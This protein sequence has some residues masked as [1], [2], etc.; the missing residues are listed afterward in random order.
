MLKSLGISTWVLC[1]SHMQCLHSEVHSHCLLFNSSKS[2][3]PQPPFSASFS[4]VQLYSISIFCK[5]VCVPNVRELDA[6]GY[7]YNCT[8]V[9][10][11]GQKCSSRICRCHQRD[12]VWKGIDDVPC[13]CYRN[14]AKRWGDRS[15]RMRGSYRQLTWVF[16]LVWYSVL[17]LP[18][19]AS[20]S[21]ALLPLFPAPC[22]W[23]YVL[24]FPKPLLRWQ[25]KFSAPSSL[26]RKIHS[27]PYILCTYS[28]MQDIHTLPFEVLTLSN[29]AIQLRGQDFLRS[30]QGRQ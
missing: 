13:V 6:L 9:M 15:Q 22:L 30:E 23:K 28:G 26:Y 8:E 4:L 20:F 17:I 24:L 10:S 21:V 2:R 11:R 19:W 3:I 5:G 12:Y 27:L 14:T 7:I 1:C 18:I 25:L 16:S 29:S